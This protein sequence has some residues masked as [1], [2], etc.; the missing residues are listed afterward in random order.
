MKKIYLDYNATTPLH[1]EVIEAMKPYL[2]DYF[3]N[4]SSSHWF[5]AQTRKAVENARKQVAALINCNPDEIIFTSGG[6]ESNNYAIKGFAFA[7]KSKGNHII[8][9]SIEHPAV[10]E[11]CKYL[12]EQGFDITYLSVDETGLV[13][14][15]EVEESITPQ[16][17]LITIMHANNEVGTIQPIVS[18]ASIARKHQIAVHTDAAQSIG[19]IPVDVEELSVDLLS[20]A[21]HKFYAPKGIGALYIRRGIRLEKQI[22]GADHEQ[23][24][25]AG[26][27]NVLEIVGFGKACEIAKRDIEKN[28]SFFKSMRDRLLQK[29]SERIKDL[30]VNGHPD[31]CL[32]NTLNVSFKNIDANTLLSE[33]ETI[34]ASAGAACHSDKTE[35]SSVLTAMNVSYEEALGAIR[36]STGRFTTPR[37]IDQAAG[38]IVE[39]YQRVI[40]NTDTSN[41]TPPT[42]EKIKLTQY[43]HGLGCACKLKPQVLEK[44]IRNNPI[45]DDPNV[46][47][48]VSTSDDAAVYKLNEDTAIVKTIDFFT[49]MVNDPYFFGAIGAANALSDIYAMGAQPL[50]ALNIV[51]FPVNRLPLE[52]LE[53]ILKGANDK[54]KEAGISILGGHS[55]EDNEPKFGMVVTGKVH[56]KKILTNANAQ[57][58]DVILLTKPIGLGIITTAIKKDLADQETVDLAT[59][60]MSTL[61][62]TAAQIMLNYPVN[63]CTDVTGFGLLGHLL[64]TT[65]S[66]KVDAEI[67]IDKIPV[68]PEAYN[69]ASANIIP[70][71]T[72][73]NLEFVTKSIKWG[74]EVAKIQQ[75]ILSDAQTSGGLLIFLPEKH[76]EIIVRDLHNHGVSEASIIGVIAGKGKG[77]INVY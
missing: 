74:A 45:P 60:I 54:A 66:G 43:T 4:P 58:G 14:I 6:T 23:N 62:K 48:G 63:S 77:I 40:Q 46:L 1:E 28:H 20:V 21:G 36:F 47:V 73:N 49:P 19:K 70:G 39:A 8:T 30:K 18:I 15:K 59:K 34:A 44:I 17:I 31:L 68:I 33:L 57:P 27:E 26:T 61:N 56:P 5:G 37:E 53:T 2:G 9:S 11:V 25:R 12:E 32:P 50:F 42:P 65:R 52:V 55:I 38:Q 51:G 41:F 69:F 22:H 24:L 29:L 7:N 3:G 13:N 67:Y 75:I 10:T 76:A 72:Y 64:E 16:T 35:I 71:G